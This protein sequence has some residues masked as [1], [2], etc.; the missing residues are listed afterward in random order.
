MAASDEESIFGGPRKVAVPHEIGQALDL[1]SAP[2]LAERIEALKLEILRL[3]AAIR[4]R[5][6]TKLAASAFFKT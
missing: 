2:E 3:E 6:A 1:L 4:Q 5:E